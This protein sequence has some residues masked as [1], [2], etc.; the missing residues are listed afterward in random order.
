VVKK[1]CDRLLPEELAGYPAANAATPPVRPQAATGLQSTYVMNRSASEIRSSREVELKF[2]VPPPSRVAMSRE[3]RSN[4]C[5]TR[6]VQSIY[7]DTADDSFEAH[8]Q[9]V[10]LRKEGQRWVQTAKAS[11]SDP[12]CRLEH[13]VRVVAPRGRRSPEPDL[14]LHDDTPVGVALR[15]TLSAIYQKRGDAVL[16]ERFRVDISRMSRIES[17]DGTRIELALDT[18]SVLAGARSVAIC[19]FEM[20]MMAGSAVDFIRQASVWSSGKG[21]W[22]STLSRSEQGFRLAHGNSEGRP[23]RA[24]EAV[25]ESNVDTAGFLASTLASC[26]LQILGNASEIAAGALDEQFVHQLRVGLRRIRT[27][28]REL[29][30]LVPGVDPEWEEVFARAF[31]ELGTHRDAVMIVPAIRAE[32]L[33]A[34][35]ECVGE[36]TSAQTMRTPQA[37][38]RDDE[39]QRT[40]LAILAFCHSGSRADTSYRRGRK[41]LQT[42][43]ARLLKSLHA[44]LS[45]DA[46]RF[47]SLSPAHQHRVRKRLKRLRYLSEFAAPLFDADRVRRYLG[48]WRQAQDALG[49]FIDHRIGLAAFNASAEAEPRKPVLVWFAHRIRDCVKRSERTL[50]KAAR[51]PVFWEK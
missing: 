41:A 49:E 51:R 6:R 25:V 40:L 28:L 31:R 38:V 48:S 10:R 13:N 29:G 44:T 26:I 12:L 42:K 2:V 46:G 8:G 50:R 22:L 1:E 30:T 21:L 15:T 16:V 34:G 45:R 27:A 32:M 11:A 39:F 47:S 24:I 36:P 23:V 20:K 17:G 3:L 35:L 4:P 5:R 7:Y 33:A 19:E 9:S 14:A 43:V 37:V 18:G